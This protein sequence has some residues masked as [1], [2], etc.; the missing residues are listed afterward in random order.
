MMRTCAPILL[1]AL[2][3]LAPALGGCSSRVQPKLTAAEQQLLDSLTRDPFVRVVATTREE[4]GFLTVHT[5]QGS[6]D[7]YYRFMPAGDGKDDL[8]VRR[9]DE[10]QEL[11]VT[12]TEGIGT[13]P[14]QRGLTR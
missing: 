14:A 12:W 6:T 4:D 3:A 5:G 10:A 8:V 1:A 7:A 2:I 9:V 13:G 11:P